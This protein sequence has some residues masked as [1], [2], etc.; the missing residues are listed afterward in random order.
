MKKE[1]TS[2]KLES[3][4][5]SWRE[6]VNHLLDMYATD[7]FIAETKMKIQHFKTSPNMMPNDYAEA[8]R[9][10]ALRYSQFYTEDTLKG[11]AVE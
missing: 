1:K 6:V 2:D 7:D 11:N 10:K 9:T 8:L 5:S 3:M 4:L